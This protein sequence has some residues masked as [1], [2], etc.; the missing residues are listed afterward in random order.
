MRSVE[1]IDEYDSPAEVDATFRTQ[2][3]V[4]VGYF[5]VFLGVIV[6]VPTLTLALEWWSQG[7]LFGGFSPNFLMTAVG[8]YAF[9]FLLAVAAAT[10]ATAVE[11]R[12]LGGSHAPFPEDAREPR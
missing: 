3:R 12:M 7:R 1:P 5:L 4:A 11:D 6:V 2:R 10:L 8:L 9:F